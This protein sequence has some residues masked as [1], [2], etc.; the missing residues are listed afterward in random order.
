[1]AEDEEADTRIQTPG[2]SVRH[3]ELLVEIGRGGMGIVYRARDRDL[4]R[5]VAL[6]RPLP[7]LL[8]SE[9]LRRRFLREGRAASRI[10][11]PNIV[12]VLEAFEED[13][14]PWIVFQLV[15]GLSLRDLLARERKLPLDTVLTYGEELASG[16]QAAHDHGV[17]HRDVN[18]KNILIDGAG[19]AL[20]T[21]FGLAHTV[22]VEDGSSTA[23]TDVGNLTSTGA[24]LGTPR[25]MA[26]E[27]LLGRPSDARTDI[28]ALGAVLYEMCCGAPA[29]RSENRGELI[30]E[31]LHR[32]PEPVSHRS[33]Q[34]PPECERIIR[35]CMAKRPDERY[36]DAKDLFAD[37]RALRRRLEFEEYSETTKAE[38]APPRPWRPRPQ[39]VILTVLLVVVA[40]VAVRLNQR[41]APAA[42]FSDARPIQVTSSSTWETQPAISPD[43]GRIAY[44][45]NGSGNL[46]VYIIGSE[47]GKPV[48]LTHDPASDHTPAWFP[49]GSAVAFVSDR[50]GKSDVWKTGQLGGE[51]TLLVEN[52]G[53]PAISPDGRRIAFTRPDSSGIHRIAVADLRNPSQAPLLTGPSDGLWDHLAPSWSPDGTRIAY[54]AFDGLWTVPAS[55]GPAHHVLPGDEA[56][57]DPVW[58]AD[59][60]TLYFASFRDGPLALWRV[61]AAGGAPARVT[62]GTGAESHPSLS[63]DGLRFAYCTEEPNNYTVVRD[64]TTG[65]EIEIA[66]QRQDLFP[67]LTPT[68]DGIVFASDRWGSR[69]DLWFQA[70]ADG[71]PSG[72]PRRLTSQEGDASHP[73]VSPDGRWVAYYLVRGNN[74]DVWVAA[75]DGG[76]PRRITEDPA[77][78]F[79]PAWSP[80]G[81]RLAF[82]S[83]R[84]GASRIWVQRVSQGAPAGEPYAV[85]GSDVGAQA[86]AWSPDGTRIAFVGARGR[87]SEVYIVSVPATA[88]ESAQSAR[89]VTAGA[90]AFRVR[91]DPTSGDLLMSGTWRT[92]RS[93]MTRIAPDGSAMRPVQP[94]VLFGQDGATT[95]GFFDVSRDGRWLVWTREAKRGD[96]WLLDAKKTQL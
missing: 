43:G 20:L 70:L 26:P 76:L 28:F 7:A 69:L 22:A 40:A 42:P 66:N 65:R 19:R 85:T 34:A 4:P 23:T 2:R 45:S 54:A 24:M 50:R 25:Y 67:A 5:E 82:A 84:A 17:I 86:P 44:V 6:K 61:P 3:Y 31:I 46:E 32:E 38:S 83:E 81:D 80:D 88:G 13:G 39:T 29:F 87:A 27:Q 53:H 1:M 94:E 68:G 73:V 18:P 89:A 51:P 79:Q 58:S 35:K 64:L 93:V 56:D 77:E 33:H 60:N 71:A 96:V 16:L 14:V 92:S 55:G 91:W 75:L 78:D 48:P 47:G 62:L 10:T 9:D 37:L 21:D 15:D 74:R 95:T 30:G 72:E 11:H 90:E 41:S 8:A 49:D 63:A 57:Q 36:Q 52:A 12:P 59:G